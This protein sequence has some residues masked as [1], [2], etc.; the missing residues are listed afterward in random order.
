MRQAYDPQAHLLVFD[1]HFCDRR[2]SVVSFVLIGFHFKANVSHSVFVRFTLC[3]EM[4]PCLRYIFLVCTFSDLTLCLI[5]AISHLGHSL[6]VS[7]SAALKVSRN[8]CN[9]LM[10][11]GYTGRAA[12]YFQHDYDLNAFQDLV[13][14]HTVFGRT[15]R[16]KVGH[17]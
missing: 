3:L 12:V 6:A 17:W 4:S 8:S 13:V 11:A 14:W 7:W 16:R 2:F 10:S 5:F 1:L 15:V 9:I